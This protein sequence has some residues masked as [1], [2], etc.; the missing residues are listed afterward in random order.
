MDF[1]DYYGVLGLKAQATD[2]EIKKSYRLLS[3]KYHP[4]KNR[5]EGAVEMFQQISKAYQILMD[6]SA[7]QAFDRLYELNKAR[8]QRTRQ[9]DAKRRRMKEDL[10]DRE[11]FAFNKAEVTAQEALRRE[12]DRLK[13]QNVSCRERM[14]NEILNARISS[15]TLQQQQASS[16]D[17]KSN[18][19]YDSSEQRTLRF[20]WDLKMIQPSQKDI[21]QLCIKYGGPVEHIVMSKKGKSALVVFQ[22]I[23]HVTNLLRIYM[24]TDLLNDYEISKISTKQ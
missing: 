21:E 2:A 14:E 4:D 11:S 10:D 8:A 24:D 13:Q 16:A 3:L 20:K 22:S 15:A 5:D 9:M 1:I 17:K 18:D 19:I 7:R 23:A 12:L 6:E